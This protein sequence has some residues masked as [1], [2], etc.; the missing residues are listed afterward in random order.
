MSGDLLSEITPEGRAS[1]PAPIGT[2]S[3]D[4][5]Q[6]AAAADQ[7][8]RAQA[9]AAMKRLATGLL[10]AMTVVFLISQALE[11]SHPWIAYVRATAEAAMVGALA[12]WFAV[13]AL[14]RHPLGIPIP[15]TAIIPSRKDDIGRGLGQFVQGNFL[16]GPVLAEKIRS[17]GVAGQ[18]GAWLAEPR[19]A[20]RLAANAGD[21]V[22]AVTEVLSD[23]DV[24]AAIEGMVESRIRAVPAAPTAGR[25]REP[26]VAPGAAR[27][28]VAVVGPRCDRR[29]GFRQDL[30]RRAAVPQ[31]DRR[32][33]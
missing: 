13:T 23:D 18:I 12:D 20:T 28:R 16:S 2:A 33:P 25:R 24:S 11:A 32:G 4:Q 27:A 7:E 21:V 6:P 9:L 8:E 5:P 19:N 29:P 3:G 17:V 1:P 30:Q 31:R 14:F 10:C 15:H 22:Q 26:D